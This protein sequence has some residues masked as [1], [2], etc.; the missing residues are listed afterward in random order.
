MPSAVPKPYDTVQAGRATIKF[1]LGDSLEVLGRLPERSVEVVVTSPPYNLGVQYRTYDDGQ[2]QQDYLDW[3]GRWVAAVA[4][5]LTPEGSLFLNVGAKPTEPWTALDVAQAARPHLRLQNILH[6]IKSIAIEAEAA[7]GRA[8]L[9]HDLAIGHYKPINSTR[10][11]NDCHEFV[12]HFTPDGVT[13]LDRLALGVKYQDASNV[14]R[15][16]AASSGRRCRGN[17]WFIPYETIQN[18]EKDRPHPATFPSRLPEY[19]IRLQGAARVGTVADPFL[20][21][22]ATTVACARMGVSGIGVE[23]D[24]HYLK[25]AIDRTRAAAAARDRRRPVR[26]SAV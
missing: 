15:W 7:G 1:F 22:G 9:A 3:T 4:R 11:L 20:G 26:Q 23:L 19:C 16:R 25:E 24:E 2:P 8:G 10:F 17:T 21:L 13:R 18:R 5:I 12:F 14:A 6:W